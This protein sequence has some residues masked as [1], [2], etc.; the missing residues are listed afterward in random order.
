WSPD[1]RWIA[2]FSDESGEYALHLRSQNGMGEVKKINLGSRAFYYSLAW[3][4]DSKK[5]AFADNHL[6]LWYVDIDKGTPVKVASSTRGR[7][8]GQSWSPDSR[9]I[10]YTSPVQSWYGA[11]FIYSLEENKSHQITDG[12]SDVASATFDKGGKYLYF[13]ASTDIGPAVFG[14][15]M[16]SYPHR[17]T[18][19]VYVAVLRK[20]L[21]SPLAPESDEEK[22]QED[23]KDGDKPG[24]PSIDKK[25]GAANQ[26]A[27]KP[28]DKPAN[29]PQAAGAKPA[30]KKAPEPVRIDFD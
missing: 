26:A 14:F 29:N 18:R 27:D 9:W 12:L 15:D 1:G 8:F 20:D 17:P 4:P 19:S 5:I 28:D 30:G 23:K 24:E 2:Y 16:T 13:T 11:A 7:G 22:V 25:D 10:A 3:S 6:N 21:P